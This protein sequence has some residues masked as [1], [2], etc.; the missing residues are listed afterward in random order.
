MSDGVLGLIG[1]G[2]SVIST[3]G[4]AIYNQRNVKK[5]NAENEKTQNIIRKQQK[6]FESQMLVQQQEFQERITKKQIDAD[7]K[8]KARIQWITDVRNLVSEYISE[9]SDLERILYELIFPVETIQV[10]YLS[11]NP[12]NSLINELLDEIKPYLKEIENKRRLI[13][14]NS[15]KILLYFSSNDEHQEIE[16]KVLFAQNL[17][18]LLE[19]FIMKTQAKKLNPTPLDDQMP[20]QFGDFYMMIVDNIVE[21]RRV[22]RTY[23][24]KEWDKA[25]EGK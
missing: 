23:L 17:L 16:S 13:T 15:E 12:D 5:Q 7:L 11:E 9:L 22:F 18:I 19:A 14:R 3:I 20:E 2:I 25:K 4:I 24:K 10:E 6:E 8:A 1:V 21:V